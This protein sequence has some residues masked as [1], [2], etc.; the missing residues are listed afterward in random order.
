MK[1]LLNEGSQRGTAL[2]PVGPSPAIVPMKAPDSDPHKRA[3]VTVL[4]LD[5]TNKKLAHTSREAA[6]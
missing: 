3:S 2:P 5:P 4:A 1:N 6:S